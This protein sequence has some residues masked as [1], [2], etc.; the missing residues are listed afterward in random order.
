MVED[1]LECIL[2]IVKLLGLP[3]SPLSSW[4]TCTEV[5]RRLSKGGTAGSSQNVSELMHRT[6]VCSQITLSILEDVLQRSHAAVPTKDEACL[7]AHRRGLA[8]CTRRQLSVTKAFDDVEQNA[9]R[10]LLV[11]RVTAPRH[12]EDATN[13]DHVN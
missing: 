9:Q 13:L 6:G 8:V 2:K 1:V 10:V 11:S 4:D 12:G 3:K 5:A 7:R